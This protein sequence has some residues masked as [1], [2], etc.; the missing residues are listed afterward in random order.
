MSNII[1]RDVEKWSQVR[2]KLPSGLFISSFL[3][4]SWHF[5]W[6]SSSSHAT[7]EFTELLFFLYL[8]HLSQRSLDEAIEEHF[9]LRVHLVSASLSWSKILQVDL[10]PLKNIKLHLSDNTFWRAAPSHCS[11]LWLENPMLKLFKTW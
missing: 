4:F 6:E 9:D 5:K 7:L 3:W 1:D 10:C 11:K 2:L 8:W